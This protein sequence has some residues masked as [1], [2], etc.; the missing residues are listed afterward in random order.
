[1]SGPVRIQEQN[2]TAS[3]I[4]SE[5]VVTHTHETYTHTFI[6]QLYQIVS[7]STPCRFYVCT[8]MGTGQINEPEAQ[9]CP[10]VEA[11]LKAGGYVHDPDSTLV[12]R[13]SAP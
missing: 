12:P 6:V 8:S 7:I 4:H 11:G 3:E 9:K 2:R 13:G 1:V 10:H 5:M